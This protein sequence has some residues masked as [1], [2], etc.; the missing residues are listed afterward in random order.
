MH[1]IDYFEASMTVS[2]NEVGNSS[3]GVEIFE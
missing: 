1:M 2:I 3:V